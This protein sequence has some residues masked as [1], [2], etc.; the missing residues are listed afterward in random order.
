MLSALR[1]TLRRL[2]HEIGFTATV[3]LT[4]A[5]CIGANVAIYA[6]V[7]AILVRPLPFPESDRLVAVNNSYPKAGADR[8]GASAVNYYDRR[9]AIKAFSSVS[10][11]QDGSTIVGGDGAP[12]RVRIARV[13]PEFFATLGVPLALG[14]M[15]TDAEMLYGPD[16]VAVL[17]DSFWR[18]HF[19][20]DPNIVGS[21]FFNDGLPV[22]IVG[23]LPR[24]FQFLST[25]AQFFRPAAHGP[26]DLKPSNRHNNN[27]QMIARLAPGATLADARAQMDAFNQKQLTDDPFAEV[28][29]NSG[30]YSGVYPLHADH[31]RDVRAI[32]LLLQAGVL[33]LLL[34]GGINLVNLLLIRA[35]GRAKEFAVRQAL[36]A[37]RRHLAGEVMLETVLL[38]LAGGLLGLL[39]GAFG[40]DLL[41]RLGTDRL[42]LGATIEFDRRVALISLLGSL[43]LGVL[44]ALPI[45]VF[46]LRSRLAPVLHS[47]SRSGTVSRAAQRVRHGFIIAQISLAFVLLAGAGLLGVSLKRILSTS[48]GFQPDHV[49]TGSIS[50]PW[51]TYP[52][53][54]KRQAFIER[55][56]A[57]LRVQ[58]GVT[59]VGFTSSLPFTGSDNNNAVGVE[60]V[61]L[62]PGESIRTHY[63]SF[64]LGNY[65][66]ALDI[67]LL[68]GRLL[69]DADNHRDQ[70]VC[71]VDADFAHRYWPNGNALGHRVAQGVTVTDKDATTIVGVVGAVK[72][73]ELSDPS[74]LGAVYFPYKYYSSTGFSVI[75]RTPL[76]PAA[77]ADTLRKTV[78]SIDPDL[79][80]DSVKTMRALVDDSLVSRRS[81][82]VLAGAFAVVA[83]L[84][85]AIGT[86]GVLAYAVSQRRREIGVRMALGALPQ[87]V[88]RHFLVLGAKLLSA[89]IVLGVLGSWA[90]GHAMQS[91]L[92][93]VGA[94][95]PAVITAT[96]VT[97]IIVVLLATFIPAR[98]A[99]KVDPMVALRSE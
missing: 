66:R 62:A 98:R 17:T 51:K 54:A 78:L 63:T 9:Q 23:V 76:E 81:P 49:L 68:E 56:D 50:L 1:Q 90:A 4:L 39:F 74:P 7:D 52:D 3:L 6:V 18:T 8:S 72:Q 20:A 26:D 24:G 97:M 92:F 13:S 83:L 47:E 75:V 32:L 11:E 25:R 46:N 94:V 70:R 65:W 91:V 21:K 22:T 45:I 31:V 96:A 86:Y 41:S 85:A 93:G 53:P 58:P 2:A 10:I 82:A 55:L 60:G 71:V 99:T 79:P 88:L 12:D 19:N 15:F 48:P 44:L 77:L 27:Y 34:I 80:V 33:A 14:H 38:S 61:Q 87:Q 64:A 36:G 67:P 5:L 89:G 43:V 35:N 16:Q 29:R 57:A 73:N 69:E 59:A 40:I 28:V 84:L 30:Y 95:D 42:P 37:G